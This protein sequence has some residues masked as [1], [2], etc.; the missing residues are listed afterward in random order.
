VRAV[1]FAPA[2]SEELTRAG[3]IIAAAF[4]GGPESAI[5][6]GGAVD[7]V[8]LV[9]GWFRKNTAESAKLMKHSVIAAKCA[10]P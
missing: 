5:L 4:A 7:S 1:C 9:V 2:N 8:L 6:T 10:R 3:V